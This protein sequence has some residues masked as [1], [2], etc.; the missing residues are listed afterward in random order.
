[1]TSE[2]A[3]QIKETLQQDGLSILTCRF[4][5]VRQD[6]RPHTKDFMQTRAERIN[7]TYVRCAERMAEL[8]ARIARNVLADG[9]NVARPKAVFAMAIRVAEYRTKC[10]NLE[11]QANAL[12]F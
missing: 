8:R 10:A 2:Q 12:K 3:I 5:G 1:M 6:V 9:I 7:R 4:R 11:Q